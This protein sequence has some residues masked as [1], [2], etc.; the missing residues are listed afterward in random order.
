MGWEIYFTPCHITPAKQLWYPLNRKLGGPHT[1]PGR[2]GKEI[3][4]L[5]LPGMEPL[6]LRR[7][8]RIQSQHGISYSAS[9]YLI[10]T[11]YNIQRFMLC[12]QKPSLSHTISVLHSYQRSVPQALSDRKLCKSGLDQASCTQNA[13][14]YGQWNACCTEPACSG[15]LLM[16]KGAYTSEHSSTSAYH[17]IAFDNRVC[18]RKFCYLRGR[19][20][21]ATVRH[22]AGPI[23]SGTAATPATVRGT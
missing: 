19:R 18:L 10:Q 3:N 21:Y 2:Y 11:K 22:L 13:Q 14:D 6:F 15:L 17:C 12:C 1:Q 8:A 23:G 20:R 7:P 16:S 9:V 4:I 5:F